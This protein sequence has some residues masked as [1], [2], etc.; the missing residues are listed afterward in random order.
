M[1]KKIYGDA[2]PV[3][4]DR[5][6]NQLPVTKAASPPIATDRFFRCSKHPDA[7][8][9]NQMCEQMNQAM[10]FRTKECF[11]IL[12]D[13]GSAPGIQATSSAGTRDRWRFA[14]HTSPYTHAILAR[15]VMFPPSSNYGNDTYAKIKIYSDATESTLV[16]TT[17]VH[18][19]PGPSNASV[20]GWQ[21]HKVIDSFI[22]GLDADTDYFGLVSDIDYGRVQSMAIADL[23]SMTE[24]YDGY[25]P[26]NFTEQSQI[27]DVYREN[28]VAPM[29]ALWKRGAAKVFNWTTNIQSS[30]QTN[31]TTTLKNLLD[32]TSTT[33]S[34]STD[35]KS[36]V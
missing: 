32:G 34:S 27:L 23:Q 36:V 2:A 21:Y 8:A 6:V 31:T 16:S 15:T 24:N 4:G 22:D 29:P 20:G 13:L 7:S 18:Y 33:V 30:P 28:L 25:L 12:G 26:V 9:M 11:S 35:R 10:L 1:Q 17:E 14:F 5:Q 19:G 3:P